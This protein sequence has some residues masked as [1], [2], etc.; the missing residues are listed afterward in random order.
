MTSQEG[1]QAERAAHWGK[2]HSEKQID[3]PAI[4]AFLRAY[5]RK[6]DLRRLE[7]LSVK[8]FLI[9]VVLVESHISVYIGN[10]PYS[11]HTSSAAS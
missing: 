3:T 10:C 9:C 4:G 6:L 11:L 1:M 8:V 7:P 2:V 5:A